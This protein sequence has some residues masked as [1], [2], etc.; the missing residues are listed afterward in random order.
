MIDKK[1]TILALNFYYLVCRGWAK[2]VK[3]C[4]RVS[5]ETRRPTLHMSTSSPRTGSLG[6]DFLQYKHCIHFS[7]LFLYFILSPVKRTVYLFAACQRGHD[8]VSGL[9]SVKEIEEAFFVPTSCWCDEK[10]FSN[11]LFL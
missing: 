1:N 7:E 4:T 2:T 10:K 6:L 11:E 5:M 9:Y 8:C 3:L